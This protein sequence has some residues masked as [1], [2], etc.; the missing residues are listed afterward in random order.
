MHKLRIETFDKNLIIDNPKKIVL[1]DV[2]P[3][4][5]IT[6]EST[7]DSKLI[8]DLRMIKRLDGKK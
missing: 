1:I 4:K 6:V 8:S 5:R 2:R 7:I 3:D